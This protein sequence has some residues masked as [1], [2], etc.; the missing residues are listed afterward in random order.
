MCEMAV[1][2][3]VEK[4]V[5][6]NPGFDVEISLDTGIGPIRTTVKSNAA[7]AN[8]AVEDVRARLFA[9]GTELAYAFDQRGSL[10]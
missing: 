6:T 8:A 3:K 10:K 5:P 9:L 1:S 4:I 7:D 2:G